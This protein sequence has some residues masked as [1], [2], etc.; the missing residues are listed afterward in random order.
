MK[1]SSLLWQK[2]SK[3]LLNVFFGAGFD[4]G[5]IIVI[6]LFL[7]E[8]IG[9]ENYGKWSVFYQFI[10]IGSNIL[11]N[12]QVAAYKINTGEDRFIIFDK[13]KFFFSFSL[14][15]TISLYFF[16]YLLESL[17]ACISI[18]SLF[19]YQYLNTIH[20]FSS[21]TSNYTVNSG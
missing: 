21:N 4:K 20:R 8:F 19:I 17:F 13:I 3:S 2:N 16:D 5:L 7:V 12:P 1:K 9:L 10:I 15:V 6:S 18:T 11:I 14:I